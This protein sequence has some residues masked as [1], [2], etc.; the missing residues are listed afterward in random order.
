MAGFT[1]AT[2]T[3]IISRYFAQKLQNGVLAGYEAEKTQIRCATLAF[4]AA[5]C[6]RVWHS[7]CKHHGWI[8]LA[9][10]IWLGEPGKAFQKA[11]PELKFGRAN[12]RK[13]LPRSLNELV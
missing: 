4:C 6:P 11:M 10:F 7:L 9:V 13:Q 5:C 12:L 2:T 1:S 3:A 8:E